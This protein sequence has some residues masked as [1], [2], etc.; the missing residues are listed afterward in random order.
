ME[1]VC[2]QAQGRFKP[3]F[4]G[5]VKKLYFGLAKFSAAARLCAFS[6]L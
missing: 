6:L 1:I 4:A 2:P 3:D 5:V